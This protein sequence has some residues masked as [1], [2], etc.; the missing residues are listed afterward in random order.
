L[1]I[2]Y[3]LEMENLHFIYPDG[4]RAL[5]G[6]NMR[7]P[8]GAKIAVLG[9]NGA[10]KST[11]FLHFNGIYKP[12]AGILKYAGNNVQYNRAALN[13]LRRKVGIV[14]QD[15]DSQ[16]FAANVQQEVSF[17][18][19]NL[20][21]PDKEVRRRVAQALEAT[22]ISHLKDKPVHFLSYGQ[23]KRVSI[24][25]ILVM[26]PEMIIFDE[27]TACLDPKHT[28]RIMELFEK[29]NQKGTTIL[30]AT[31]DIET[32]WSWADYVF[33]LKDG[34]VLGEGTPSEIFNNAELLEKTDLEKPF[35]LE[36]FNI[37]KA[38]GITNDLPTCPRK[39]E[40]FLKYLQH[41]VKYHFLS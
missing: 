3:I 18:A 11:L 6:I 9:S 10:G 40:E 38:E 5:K 28:V 22:E 34:M 16:L 30:L 1:V 7:I 26:E 14:F 15:P 13:E 32:V 29:L 25:D 8:K 20:K 4:T 24:A 31:H 21:I 39:K 23:K 33:I 35:G 41:K 17:G 19:V 2:D 27:P 37:L 36:I 12:S